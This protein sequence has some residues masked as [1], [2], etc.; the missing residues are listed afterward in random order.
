MCYCCPRSLALMSAC[1]YRGISHSGSPLLRHLGL[2]FS[3][4]PFRLLARNLQ[5]TSTSKV[6]LSVSVS[7]CLGAVAKQPTHSN[8]Q[9]TLSHPIIYNSVRS[10]QRSKNKKGGNNE[11]SRREKA[12][13]KCEKHLLFR[14]IPGCSSNIGLHLD[15]LERSAPRPEVGQE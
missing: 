7:T 3:T 8:L 4:V 12:A 5:K 14:T 9:P 11:E 10:K 2:A 1:L 15:W 6:K 13:E